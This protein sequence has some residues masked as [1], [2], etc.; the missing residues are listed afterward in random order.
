MTPIS[1]TGTL[2]PTFKP[3]TLSALLADYIKGCHR[4]GLDWLFD[5]AASHTPKIILALL[6]LITDVTNWV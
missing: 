5:Q 3:T 4:Q 1:M 2:A 6:G